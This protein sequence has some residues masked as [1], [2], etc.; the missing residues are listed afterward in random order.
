MSEKINIG[1]M[2][3]NAWVKGITSVIKGTEIKDI[4]PPKPDLAIPYKMI[5]GTTA[6]TD[7]KFNSIKS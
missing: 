3:A 1:K 2:I 5:A 4:E 6:K 7:N